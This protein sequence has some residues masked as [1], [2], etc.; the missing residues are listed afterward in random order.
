MKDWD[1]SGTAWES[2]EDRVER[3]DQAED[4][5]D[6]VQQYRDRF[7]ASD[8]GSFDF[9]AMDNELDALEK[10]IE[11][12]SRKPDIAMNPESGNSPDQNQPDPAQPTF[13]PSGMNPL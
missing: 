12:M 13:Q 6:R 10:D 9:D 4:T 5:F 7:D 1:Q 3:R 8:S 11:N 2:F